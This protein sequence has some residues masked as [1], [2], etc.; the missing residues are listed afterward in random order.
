MDQQEL[1]IADLAWQK[2]LSISAM[3]RTCHVDRSALSRRLC[4]VTRSVN[5][6]RDDPQF[7]NNARTEDLPS[8]INKLMEANFPPTSTM[9]NRF[10]AD[11]VGQSPSSMW[12]SRW[13]HAHENRLATGW[14]LTFDRA[15]HDAISAAFYTKHFELI[16]Q[17]LTEAFRIKFLSACFRISFS[18][19]AGLRF[20]SV[21]EGQSSLGR[22]WLCLYYD[23]LEALST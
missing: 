1:A 17:R 8:Y 10:A 23:G 4:G 21:T 16:V 22:S 6:A 7:L 13:L 18:Y 11:M 5:E 2:K 14:L 20:P 3:A 9:V 12:L 19:R 15:R